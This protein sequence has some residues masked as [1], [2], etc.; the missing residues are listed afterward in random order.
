MDLKFPIRYLEIQDFLPNGDVN[1]EI[2]KQNKPILL[3]IHANWCGACAQAKPEFQKFA[4]TKSIQCDV[5]QI[6]GEP[7][8]K[9]LVPLLPKIVPN[10]Q[11]YLPSY[12]LYLNSHDKIQ[13]NGNRQSS[14]LNDFVT[15]TISTYH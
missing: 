10:W 2:N 15:N 11:S 8:E 14:D 13:Y 5:I 9:A 12:V 7:N 1:P 4:D 3:M 6:D